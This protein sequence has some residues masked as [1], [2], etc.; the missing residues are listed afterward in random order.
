MFHQNRQ[1]V[2]RAMFV[3]AMAVMCGMAVECRDA[4][5]GKPAVATAPMP[6]AIQTGETRVSWKCRC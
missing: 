2:L 1:R 5:W 4:E 6:T 3:V